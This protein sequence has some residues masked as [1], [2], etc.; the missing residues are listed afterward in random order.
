VENRCL[1]PCEDMRCSE[2][3]VC[4][5]DVRGYECMC[6]QTQCEGAY[7]ALKAL[8]Q[9]EPCSLDWPSSRCSGHGVCMELGHSSQDRYKCLCAEGW[10]GSICS[11][12]FQ[13]CDAAG[14]GFD[15]CLN[16][17]ACVEGEC[18]C[19][20]EYGGSR[21]QHSQ[22][23]IDYLQVRRMCECAYGMLCCYT[24]IMF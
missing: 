17:A 22:V 2:G 15:K 12:A 16:G 9:S 7:N 21:C 3:L 11:E 6:D 4:V 23:E 5:S 20:A 10:V 24:C 14:T 19:V 8:E 13:E 1:D 18:V